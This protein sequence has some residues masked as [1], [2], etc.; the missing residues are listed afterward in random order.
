MPGMKERVAKVDRVFEA[1]VTEGKS[2]RQQ[3]ALVLDLLGDIRGVSI[4]EMGRI[5]RPKR[6]EK[7]REEY[8]QPEQTG[9][10]RGEEDFEGVQDMFG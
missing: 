1:V 4:H 9:I 5:E 6:R 2:E 3:R 8:M 7:V 10:V